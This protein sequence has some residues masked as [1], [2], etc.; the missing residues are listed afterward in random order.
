MKQNGGKILVENI[1][2]KHYQCTSFSV[3]Y[4]IFQSYSQEYDPVLD[5]HSLSL[6]LTIGILHN[7]NIFGLRHP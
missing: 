3:F 1:Y 7:Y 2:L 6:S 5:I 4:E